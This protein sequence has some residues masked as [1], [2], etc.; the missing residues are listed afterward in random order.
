MSGVILATAIGGTAVGTGALVAAGIGAG[1]TLYGGAKSFSDASKARK[2]GE[3]AQR[4]AIKAVEEAKKR[5]DINRMEQLSIA[6]E[7]YELM[8]E[9]QLV[10]GATGMQAGVEG[11]TRGAAATAGRIQM[12]QGQQQAGIRAAQ[13]QQMD[14]L[15]KLIAQ[16]DARIDQQLAGI[17]MTEAAGAQQAIRDAQEDRAAY[18]AQG[19]GTLGSIA[20]GLS[21]SYA[22]GNFGKT[23]RQQEN[24]RLN[25]IQQGVEAA[26][27]RNAALRPVTMDG[28]DAE[29]YEIPLDDEGPRNAFPVTGTPAAGLGQI[30][31]GE[32][33]PPQVP[34]VTQA[35]PMITGPG[36]YN[37]APFGL[38]P[39]QGATTGPLANPRGAAAPQPLAPV[40]LGGTSIPAARIQGGRREVPASGS[41][42][43]GL[44]FNEKGG[45]PELSLEA[46]SKTLRDSGLTEPQ[47]AIALRRAQIERDGS[48]SFQM[49]PSELFLDY[50]SQ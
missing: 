42:N 37:L 20:Q 6:K 22:E 27:R 33:A 25:E 13:A 5:I 21:S 28:I 43:D 11:E 38:L 23:R 34:G 26:A 45:T 16:E 19:V 1:T 50:F 7:P 2:R 29:G 47:V 9:A 40:G 32:F 3:A 12:A 30:S 24:E 14:Q 49:P 15:N 44:F 39:S 17:A 4:A 18:I 8:R 31:T 35:Q 41:F 48:A 10:Q 36:G 46:L